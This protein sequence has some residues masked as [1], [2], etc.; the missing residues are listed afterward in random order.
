M[1]GVFFDKIVGAL[2]REIKWAFK[3]RAQ[4]ESQSAANY[5]SRYYSGL[6]RALELL[7]KAKSS[8]N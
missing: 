2:D 3:T 6:K 5:W 7:L 8:L 4:A 1:N